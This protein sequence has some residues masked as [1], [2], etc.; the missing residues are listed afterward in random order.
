MPLY[1]ALM[2]S[3]RSRVGQKVVGLAA[4]TVLALGLLVVPAGAARADRYYYWNTTVQGRT[5]K[6]WMYGDAVFWHG[7]IA[8]GSKGDVVKLEWSDDGFKTYQ[9]WGATIQPGATSANTKDE[10]G[11]GYW[12]KFRACGFVGSHSGCTSAH[13]Y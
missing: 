6:L 9:F 3:F 11:Q 13:S 2:N 4:G 7:Q 1:A 5:V 8:N 10:D 12:W